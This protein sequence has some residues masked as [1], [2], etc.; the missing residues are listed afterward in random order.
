MVLPGK[1]WSKGDYS[2]GLET[3][4]AEISVFSPNLETYE[5]IVAYA[6]IIFTRNMG[7]LVVY[8]ARCELSRPLVPD[9][10]I[11]RGGLTQFAQGI[12]RRSGTGH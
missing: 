7:N 10:R 6:M 1:G 4:I 8:D 9:R 2:I 3:G 5:K 12:L 11:D